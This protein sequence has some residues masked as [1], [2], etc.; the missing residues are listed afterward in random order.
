MKKSLTLFFAFLLIFS[1][2]SYLAPAS[3]H[4]YADN[5][6]YLQI[7]DQ[8]ITIGNKAIERTID[9]TDQTLQTKEILNKR[10]EK[11]IEPQN[12]SE[13]FIVNLLSE[14]LEIEDPEEGE[15]APEQLIPE[16]QKPS[17]AIDR[18][19]WEVTIVG[20]SGKE[21]DG[22]ELIDNDIDSFIDFSD[23]P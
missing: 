15:D 18:S 13:D 23:D 17:N 3:H 4:V 10:I 9:L 11:L 5:D 19:N 20:P 7:D 12:G 1:N 21:V 8:Q 14:G 6:S 16:E 2:L 22:Q